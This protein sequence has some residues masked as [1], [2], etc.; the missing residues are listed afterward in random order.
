M[1]EQLDIPKGG[2]TDFNLNLI[3]NTKVNSKWIR[4]LNVR[5]KKIKLLEEN[6][7]Q[8]LNVIGFGNDVLDTTPKA[9]IMGKNRE[10]GVHENVQKFEY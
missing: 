4:N 9:Q 10:I 7:R 8:N 1:L 3:V 2:K 6:L 5:S